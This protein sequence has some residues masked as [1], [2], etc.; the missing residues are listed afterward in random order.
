VA[1]RAHFGPVPD[2]QQLNVHA[3]QRAQRS[4]TRVDAASTLHR[5]ST[6]IDRARAE[7]DYFGL[8]RLPLGGRCRKSGDPVTTRLSVMSGCPAL[9][10]MTASRRAP[11]CEAAARPRSAR[12]A[13]AKAWAP[14]IAKAP[15][16]RAMP[17]RPAEAMLAPRLRRVPAK[18]PRAARRAAAG[19]IRRAASS[20]SAPFRLRCIARR[21]SAARCAFSDSGS[22]PVNAGHPVITESPVVNGSPAFAGDDTDSQ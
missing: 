16:A 22:C 13:T 20:S 10:G 21:S 12:A 11:A 19:V 1:T 4:P 7:R 15:P 9:A 3:S 17:A 5:F 6:P 8:H 18:V 2:S 14:A